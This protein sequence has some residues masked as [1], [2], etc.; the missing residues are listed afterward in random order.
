VAE[1]RDGVRRAHFRLHRRSKPITLRREQMVASARATGA[2]L[3]LRPGAGRWFACNSYIA[4]R[5][6]LVRAWY[7]TWR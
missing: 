4:G 2:A 6:M 7:W 5:M 3:N 1:R